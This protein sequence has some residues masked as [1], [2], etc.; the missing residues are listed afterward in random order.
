MTAELVVVE[1]AEFAGSAARRLTAEIRRVLEARERCSL[2]LPGGSTPTPVYVHLAAELPDQEAWRR[3]DVFF[4]DER[5]VPPGDPASNYRMVKEALLDRVPIGRLQVHRM[6]GER[7]DHHEVA[8]AYAAILPE[9]LDLLVLGLGKDGHTASLF[10]G[11]ASLAES[12]RRVIA[13]NAPV[14]PRDRLTITPPVIR[15][16]RLVIGLVAGAE[17]ASALARVIDGPYDP[18]R[19]PGQLARAGLWI[20]DVAAAA[21]LEARR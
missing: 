4:G 12:A 9:R 8:R 1:R 10:P 2:A 13:V 21:Q 6:K 7:P 16:A 11:A 3:I 5:C 15:D 20:A 14:P 19:T 17:K 18:R